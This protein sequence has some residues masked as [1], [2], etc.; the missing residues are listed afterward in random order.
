MSFLLSRPRDPFLWLVFTLCWNS[1]PGIISTGWILLYARK[2]K[3]E[4]ELRMT[5]RRA[6]VTKDD[7]CFQAQRMARAQEII[8]QKVFLVGQLI[9]PALF[10]G[11]DE[12]QFQEIITRKPK[13]FSGK[14][15]LKRRFIR[16]TQEP[17]ARECPRKKKNKH[18]P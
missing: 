15:P 9:S 2:G 1:F 16:V 12:R 10:K 4:I 8:T 5:K 13:I 17:R 6:L 7:G 14:Q 11:S 18:G 3:D